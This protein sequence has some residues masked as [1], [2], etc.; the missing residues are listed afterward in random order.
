MERLLDVRFNACKIIQK[1][2]YINIYKM[3]NRRT[4]K[5]R[6]ELSLRRKYAQV[7]KLRKKTTT[8][9]NKKGG[10]NETYEIIDGVMYAYLNFKINGKFN[11]KTDS[12][13]TPRTFKKISIFINFT[14]KHHTGDA[15]IEQVAELNHKDEWVVHD[16]GGAYIVFYYKD[17]NKPYYDYYN[18]SFEDCIKDRDFYLVV[19][20]TRFGTT[21]QKI[22]INDIGP[23]SVETVED[24]TKYTLFFDGN[25]WTCRFK[26]ENGYI[27]GEKLANS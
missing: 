2:F 21:Y 23:V 22:I 3:R 13:M 12:A 1:I 24:K 19:G 8:R 11:I 16:Y 5:K 6:N 9:R 15:H 17:P 27:V 20:P 10:E 25:K 14:I 4:A 7:V 26:R 18:A